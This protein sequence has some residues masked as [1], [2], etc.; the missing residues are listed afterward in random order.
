[1][2]DQPTNNF[3][4]V[5]PEPGVGG[6]D[7]KLNAALDKVDTLFR[8]Q[9]AS[10]RQTILSAK[11]DADGVADFFT[12]GSGLS[13]TLDAT[14][15]DFVMSF[16][17]G[18]KEY[19]FT[20]TV[21]QAF[22]ATATYSL[23]YVDY[24]PV[25]DTVTYGQKPNAEAFYSYGAVAPSSPVTGQH[26]F[27]NVEMKMYEYDGA[28]WVQRIR[29]LLGGASEFAGSITGLYSFSIN[30][31]YR[32]ASIAISGSSQ[33]IVIH[34]VHEIMSRDSVLLPCAGMIAKAFADGVYEFDNTFSTNGAVLTNI[35]SYTLT[36][37]TYAAASY[38]NQAGSRVAASD[39]VVMVDR[40]W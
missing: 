2:A 24:D 11:T 17:D 22:V 36:M 32:S 37:V 33:Y 21:D 28:A 39:A 34:G 1:M 30:G 10:R 8:S 20:E 6:W 3:G 27:N 9:S 29:L 35:Q 7:A 31:R 38:I 25:T 5:K 12:A 4:I 40:G 18:H 15:A 23:Y 14:T 26:F 13:F 19:V 16:S